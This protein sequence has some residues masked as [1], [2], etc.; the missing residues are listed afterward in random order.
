M[1]R[2]TF[3]TSGVVMGATPSPF[4][5]WTGAAEGEFSPVLVGCR[6][7]AGDVARLWKAAEQAPVIDS[8]YGGGTVQTSAAFPGILA[9]DQIAARTR[10]VKEP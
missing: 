1:D 4:R 10:E 8:C 7:G 2:R 9:F 6:V 5:R 3:L